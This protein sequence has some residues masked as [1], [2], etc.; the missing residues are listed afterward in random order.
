M[1]FLFMIVG[2]YLIIPLLNKIVE[3]PKMAYYF[4]I[5]AF[6]FSFLIPQ[7][8]SV[9]GLKYESLSELVSTLISK[10]HVEM[11]LGYSGYFV[12]GYLLKRMQIRKK[13]E[14]I[15][16]IYPDYAELYLLYLARC[17]QQE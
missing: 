16:Y 4:V 17:G 8:I 5:L 7:I 12:L 14:S 2:L 11:V 15:I 10:F 9:I 3:N 1:W 13:L 6:F